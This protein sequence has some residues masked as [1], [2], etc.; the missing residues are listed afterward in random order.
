MS[1]KTVHLKDDQEDLYFQKKEKELLLKLRE[2]ATEETNKQY[3]EEHR[4]HCF[5]CGTA[6][7]VE[8]EKGTLKVDIC[9]NKNCGAVHLDPGELDAIVK[10]QRVIGSVRSAILNVFK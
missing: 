4:G 10:N 1:I 6:S 3:R 8:V 5:R 2:K 7:L 9:V